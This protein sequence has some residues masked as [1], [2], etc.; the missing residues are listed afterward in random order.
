MFIMIVLLL[1]MRFRA[2]HKGVL[3]LGLLMVHLYYDVVSQ[4]RTF[5]VVEKEL[6]S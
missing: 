4:G 5:R 6:L 3:G 2:V 1:S